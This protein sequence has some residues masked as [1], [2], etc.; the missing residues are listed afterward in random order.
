MAGL[1]HRPAHAVPMDPH[2]A[3]CFGCGPDNPAGLALQVFQVGDEV[4][5]DLSFDHRHAG[6]HG[7][8]HGG[9][10]ASACDDLMAFLLYVVQQPAVTRSL[11]VDYL[12]PVPV[13]E[14]HRIVAR[15]TAREGRRL[16]MRAEGSAANGDVRFTA[17]AVFV[18]VELSHFDGF[19]SA[20]NRDALTQFGVAAPGAVPGGA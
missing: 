19:G 4:L 15:I 10:L 16:T 17:Q 14:P 6:A 5:T 2:G 12:A 11:L 1:P 18:R 8:V 20:D 13:D 9:V 7:V 3:R